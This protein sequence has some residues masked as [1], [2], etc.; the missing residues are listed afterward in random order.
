M[1]NIIVF[2]GA[3]GGLFA[4][5]VRFK[6][7]L[8]YAIPVSYQYVL[9]EIARLIAAR[10]TDP[11]VVS[12]VAIEELT[13]RKPNEAASTQCK[14][15]AI[16]RQFCIWL[17][18][19]GYN[20]VTPA[21]GLARNTTDFVPRIVSTPEMASI[22]KIADRNESEQRRLLLRLLWCCGMRIGEACALTISDIDI[23][24]GTILVTHAKGDRTRL[25]PMS[26]SLWEYASGYL[27]RCGLADAD[28][29][30]PLIPTA[31]GNFPR[32][33]NAGAALS[34]IF[35]RAS[36]L[37]RQG[38]PIRPHDL[39]HS[40]AV[41]ALEKMVDTGMDIYVALPL[42]ATYMGHVDIN[43]TEYYLRFTED[44]LL[45]IVDAQQTVSKRVFGG[46]L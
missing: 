17:A 23:S 1:D 36:V 38:T 25:L 9:R 29:A 39:R 4:G 33:N 19:K 14:R 41:H 5:Y 21:E 6:R 46:A 31:R 35:A 2:P 27:K 44:T 45:R 32:S 20:P 22:L 8:G 3:R 24:A 37:T 28:S 40:Y 18:T 10:E 7:S 15:I 42:L 16:L 11:E 13:A 43:S 34:P 12:R 26:E 30:M